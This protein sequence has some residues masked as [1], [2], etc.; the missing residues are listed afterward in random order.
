[1]NMVALICQHRLYIEQKE[2]FSCPTVTDKRT[3]ELDQLKHTF[4]SAELKSEYFVLIDHIICFTLIPPLKLQMLH[5]CFTHIQVKSKQH[6]TGL[7]EKFVVLT[8]RKLEKYHT[9]T[10][11]GAL[12]L[13]KGL[14]GWKTCLDPAATSGVRFWMPKAGF[15]CLAGNSRAGR[16]P[17][18]SQV[19]FCSHVCNMNGN[20]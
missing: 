2:R 8:C 7:H 10:V 9:P 5:T 11:R 17:N 20:Q 6:G 3:T 18:E 14:F 19:L 16:Q 4:S 12:S 13:Y 15:S 1:M